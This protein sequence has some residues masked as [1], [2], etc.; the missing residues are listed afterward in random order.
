MSRRQIARDAI[1]QIRFRLRGATD[2]AVN[3]L[4]DRVLEGIKGQR[5]VDLARMT[6][7]RAGRHPAARLS[8]DARRSCART[9]TRGDRAT[10]RP[11]RPSPRPRYSREALAMDGAFGTRWEIDDGVYTGRLGRP[12]RLRRGQGAGAAPVRRRAAASTSRSPGR[13][14]TP[15]P[16]CRCSR[17]SA[18]RSRSTPTPASPRSPGARAGRCCAS[19]SWASGCGVAGA[20]A[21]RG[22]GRRKRQLARGAPPGTGAAPQAAARGFGRT[23]HPRMT[24]WP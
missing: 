11:P 21:G 20:V 1:D 13:T 5:V 14:P 22:G 4:L 3:V 10:S 6:P 16:T 23:R 24:A 8:A 15:P 12:V 17:P 2:A 18:I 9:R 19:R 7:G